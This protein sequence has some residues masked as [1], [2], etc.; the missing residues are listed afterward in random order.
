MDRA[1]RCAARC[2]RREVIPLGV[3]QHLRGGGPRSHRR[4]LGGSTDRSSA[5]LV[6]CATR[7]RQRRACR[8]AAAMAVLASNEQQA[9]MHRAVADEVLLRHVP[10]AA[11]AE[12]WLGSSAPSPRRAAR[13]ARRLLEAAR[14]CERP[15][16]RGPCPVH[17]GGQDGNGER[18]ADNG[19]GRGS[20]VAAGHHAHSGR[21][22]VAPTRATGDAT[23]TASHTG[24]TDDGYGHCAKTPASRAAAENLPPGNVRG[25]EGREEP[26]WLTGS[27]GVRGGPP[28]P[29]ATAADLPM[30]AAG[31]TLRGGVPGRSLT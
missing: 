26:P 14:S 25:G 12:P 19:T 3:H 22:P 28:G 11:V 23:A 24:V 10:R 7:S 13:T 5:A 27:G 17:R 9:D 6:T 16:V 18:V 29:W 20:C 4:L 21:R 8:R 30:T 15:P 1:A 31:P 2:V